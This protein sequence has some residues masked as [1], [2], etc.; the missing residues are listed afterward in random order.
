MSNKISSISAFLLALLNFY[1]LQAQHRDIHKINPKDEVVLKTIFAT[2]NANDSLQARKFITENCTPHFRDIVPMK[3]HQGAFLN[4]YLQ[5]GGLILDSTSVKTTQEKTLASLYCHDK[6]FSLNHTITADFSPDHKVNGLKIRPTRLEDLHLKALNDE[7]FKNEIADI[8][9][10]TCS[11]DAFSG[12]VLV[13]KGSQTLFQQAC[14]EASKSYHIANKID[15]KFN[16]G[17]MNKMFTAISVMQLWEQG[18]IALSDPIS[19]F[20][21]DSWLPKIITDKITIQHLLTHTSGL[22]S[23]F[24]ETFFNSSRELY[25]KVDDYKPLIKN[26]TLHFE[27]G[28]KYEYSNTGMLLLGVV[29]EKA[30]GKDYFD[31]I[32]NNVYQPAGML[33]SD[34]YEL[35]EPIENMAVGYIKTEKGFENN[36]FRHVLKGGPA[37]GG[38]ATAPDLHKFAMALMDGKLVNKTTL[39]KMFKDDL[40]NG[41]GFG[42]EIKK[43]ASEKVIGHSGGFSGISSNLEIFSDKGYTSIVLSNY[44]GSGHTISDKVRELIYRLEK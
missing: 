26:D 4:F 21:D 41:Y 28:S 17:S 37:G 7:T 12:V 23:Y 20:V 29:I 13:A 33:H 3:G 32:R 5:T 22:G 9:K 16:L 14:G 40:G 15:T 38:Y 10:K 44:S 30:S 1:S 25:R 6:N 19:N 35:D 43:M 42:F 39:E 31:Y 36:T 27:P 2:I 34:S 18:K 24:N 11:K 8:I